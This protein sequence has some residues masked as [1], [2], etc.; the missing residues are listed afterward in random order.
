MNTVN[1]LRRLRFRT[2]SYTDKTV[3]AKGNTIVVK[4]GKG[5][6]KFYSVE[7]DEGRLEIGG[8][9]RKILEEFANCPPERDAIMNFTKEYGPLCAVPDKKGDIRF[10]LA[11]WRDL[12][13]K[14]K[15]IWNEL[16]P[17]R[18]VKFPNAQLPTHFDEKFVWWF[19]ELTYQV[20]DLYRL[21]LLE[22]YSISR[23]RVR[24]CKHANCTQ[25]YFIAEH[26][27]RK[28]CLKCREVARRET[29]RKS[30]VRNNHRWA[31]RSKSHK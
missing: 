11:E 17:K 4:C 5:H 24:K 15:Q 25:P 26:L 6:P 18:K 23:Q 10:T 14:Y 20:A 1:H 22:L 31:K 13:N 9:D 27:G 29:K 16:I 21:L 30:W 3:S 19:S 12:Q 2:R 7:I 28:Y 8:W